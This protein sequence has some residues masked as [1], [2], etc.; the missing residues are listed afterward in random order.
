MKGF[1]EYKGK[2]GLHIIQII[3]GFN[4]GY[5]IG[6]VL[7]RIVRMRNRERDIRQDMNDCIWML[8][9]YLDYPEL[10]ARSTSP[11]YPRHQIEGWLAD[12]EMVG[13]GRANPNRVLANAFRLI[14]W[15][16]HTNR[17]SELC[18]INI[19]G[20]MEDLRRYAKRWA[21]E[22]EQTKKL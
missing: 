18:E 1:D 5:T 7:E 20:A 16:V 19:K 17:G 21:K 8:R 10:Q 15:A 3:E 2:S 13:I 12:F 6:A 22:Q 14:M 4:L 9:Y 11:V